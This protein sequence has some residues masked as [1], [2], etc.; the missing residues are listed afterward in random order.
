MIE[1]GG[2]Q[3]STF[4]AGGKSVFKLL[5]QAEQFVYFYFVLSTKLLKN[6]L[7]VFTLFFFIYIAYL[8]PLLCASSNYVKQA[9]YFVTSVAKKVLMFLKTSVE[10]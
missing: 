10:F 2:P 7:S 5:L 8:K 1:S 6:S 3:S 4:V 9:K